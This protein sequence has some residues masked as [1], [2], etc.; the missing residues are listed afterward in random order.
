MRVLIE[1]GSIYKRVIFKREEVRREKRESTWYMMSFKRHP[2]HFY[3]HTVTL[4]GTL[5]LGIYPS[6][7]GFQALPLNPPPTSLPVSS[8]CFL[9][10]SAPYPCCSSMSLDPVHTG[11]G[12]QKKRGRVYFY[13]TALTCWRRRACLVSSEVPS[14]KVLQLS[15]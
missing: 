9:Q 6:L 4:C 12:W 1:R 11:W 13:T 15:K 2:T 3:P 14:E 5:L 7:V 10:L 8:Q